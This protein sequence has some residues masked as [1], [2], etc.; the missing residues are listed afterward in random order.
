MTEKRFLETYKFKMFTDKHDEFLVKMLDNITNRE[1]GDYPC[2]RNYDCEIC[3][4]SRENNSK[5]GMCGGAYSS[6]Y[7][8]SDSEP[9]DIFGLVMAVLNDFSKTKIFWRVD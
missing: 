1:Y 5:N 2:D 3:P 7:R 8:F 4:F 6:M 9:D